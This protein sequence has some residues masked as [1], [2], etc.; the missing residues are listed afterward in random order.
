MDMV[1]HAYLVHHSRKQIK[2]Q[3]N[4]HHVWEQHA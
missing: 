1:L 2:L 4:K 3:R